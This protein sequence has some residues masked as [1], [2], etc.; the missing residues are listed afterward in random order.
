MF[1]A[2]DVQAR[3][4]SISDFKMSPKPPYTLGTHVQLYVKSN[5]GTVRFEINGQAKAE[6]GSSEQWETWKTEEFG[7]GTHTVCAVARGDGGWENAD[8][9]CQDVYVSGGQAP[10]TGGTSGRCY[11]TSFT[12]TPASGPIGTVFN[13]SSQGQCDGNMRAAKYSIDGSGFGEHSNNTYNTGWSSSGYSSGTH[14]ICYLV[15]SD[16][17]SQAA[18]SCVTIS[19]TVDGSP[20][21]DVTEG[22]QTAPETG[23][24]GPSGQSQGSDASSCQGSALSLSPG[25]TAR[26]SPGPDNNLRRNPSTDSSL[27]GSIPAGGSFTILDGPRCGNGYWWWEVDYNGKEGWTAQ[28]DEE[29]LWFSLSISPPS[30]PTATPRSPQATNTPLP[31]AIQ[32]PSEPVV[33][34]CRA[35][36]V[37]LYFELNP[38]TSNR[39]DWVIVYD[40]TIRVEQGALEIRR[41]GQTV[42]K[43]LGLK[44]LEGSRWELAIGL[45]GL[46]DRW[47]LFYKVSGVCP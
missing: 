36:P 13:L 12:V 10:T 30:Q 24:S 25:D 38:L 35:E 31:P 45:L 44:Q 8:R 21:N 43:E 18:Q 1:F 42:S 19:L 11:V 47:E 2:A 27:I 40:T 7:S 20:G 5:C 37:G 3:G 4:C 33:R 15:T 23:G 22:D 46:L 32:T 16:T 6:I 17:W 14:T 26:I 41:D 9:R 34:S 39:F 28:G 29:N